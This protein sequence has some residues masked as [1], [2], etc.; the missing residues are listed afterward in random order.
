MTTGSLGGGAGN[1]QDNTGETKHIE[2]K[3]RH[4]HFLIRNRD[5]DSTVL[6]TPRI[7]LLFPFSFI[8]NNN[9][10]KLSIGEARPMTSVSGAGYKG[11]KPAGANF[12]PMNLGKGERTKHTKLYAYFVS[13]LFSFSI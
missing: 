3:H 4:Y 2:I 8:R 1:E 11:S 9:V 10:N 13:H 6:P 7:Q 5:I 12:D